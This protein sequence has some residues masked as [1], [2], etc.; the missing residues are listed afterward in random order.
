MSK[1]PCC[2]ATFKLVYEVSFHSLLTRKPW[3]T[4]TKYGLRDRVS[5]LRHWPRGTAC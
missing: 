4:F 1:V 3:F 2:L 5:E